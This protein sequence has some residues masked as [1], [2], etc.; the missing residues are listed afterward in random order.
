MAL[1]KMQIAEQLSTEYELGGKRQIANI[2]DGL[3]DLAASQLEAGED[4]TVPGIAKLTYTYRGKRPKGDKYKKGETYV[5]F[6]G[7]EVT[8]EAD[9]KPVTEMVKLRAAPAGHAAKLKPGAKPEAQKAFLASKTGK[10]VRKR[11]A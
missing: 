7:V 5:G 2:L 4:F 9:S 8:A 6:G 11:K 1:T 3:A 10:A